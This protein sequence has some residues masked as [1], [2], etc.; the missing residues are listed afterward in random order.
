MGSLI[1]NINIRYL[2]VQHWTDAKNPSLIVHLTENNPDVILFTSTSKLNT[3][4][5]INIPHYNSFTTNK[6]NE[7]HS[8]SGIAIKHGIRFEL[9]NQFQHDTI[10]AKIETNHGPIIVMTSYAPPR[11]RF[12]PRHDIEFMTRHQLP[13]ILAG[14]LNCRHQM[15]GYTTAPNH[16][17]RALHQYISNN[18][19]NYLGP[20]FPTFYTR[21]YKTKPDCVLANNKFFL[22]YHIQ[23]GGIGPSDHITLDIT[24]SANPIVVPRSPIPDI[25]KTDWPEYKRL[26]ATEPIINIDGGSADDILNEFDKIYRNINSAKNLTT[27]MKTTTT[28]NS[29]QTTAKFK[30]LTKILDNYYQSLVRHGKNEHLEKVIRNI[31]LAL[32]EEGNICKYNWWLK[33]IERIELSANC[34]NKF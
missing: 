30:R 19:L 11:Q 16:K 15:F 33:Q 23:A 13:T 22:N 21:N 20:N 24:L 3:D 34:N 17:G 5:K 12:L 6:L 28:I 10:G 26:L 8:G 14:D 32:I 29:L 9:L 4:P 1:R 31:Q 18:R 2:N 27:P 25:E 7:R